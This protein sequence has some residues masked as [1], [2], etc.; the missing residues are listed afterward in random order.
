MKI[1][2]SA[3][4]TREENGLYSVEFPNLPGC[5]TDGDSRA[6]AV[7]H[8]QDALYGWLAS[9]LVRGRVFDPSDTPESI[10]APRNGFVRLIAPSRQ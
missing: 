5:V 7:S 6:D 9:H 10:R 3:L 1:E 8:A 2:Y 4:F